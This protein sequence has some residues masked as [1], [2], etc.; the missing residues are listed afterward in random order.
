RAIDVR[1]LTGRCLQQVLRTFERLLG[2]TVLRLQLIHS[3]LV[4][5]DLSLKGRLLEKVEEI[6]LLDL[7]AL[8]KEPLFKKGG[9]PGDERYP[10]HRLDAADELVALSDLLTLGAHDADRRRPA[11]RRLSLGPGREH[12]E[13]EE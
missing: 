9:D 3:R 13:D 10:P 6:A 11:R 5:L 2:I 8:H 4:G 12:D 1:M 7:R